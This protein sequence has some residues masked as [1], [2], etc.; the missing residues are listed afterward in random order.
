M[1]HA[2]LLWQGF[3]E[4][5]S[6]L[7]V[8]DT[9][10]DVLA[11]SSAKYD[12]PAVFSDRICDLISRA[13]LSERARATAAERERS[14]AAEARCDKLAEALSNC[15]RVI[16]MLVDPKAI[17]KTSSATVWAQCVEAETRAREALEQVGK[18]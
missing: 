9:I 6:S 15:I 4:E 7:W 2:A 14:E 11:D 10:L 17:A 5:S 13:I 18:R 8:G 12:A 3:V 16:Q 1:E